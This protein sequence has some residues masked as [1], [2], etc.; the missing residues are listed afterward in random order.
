MFAIELLGLRKQIEQRLDAETFEVPPLDGR[1]SRRRD[2]PD[3]SARAIAPRIAEVHLAVLDDRV[4]P[5][6]DVDRAVGPHLHVHRPEGAMRRDEEV[7]GLSRDV[8]GAVVLEHERVHAIAAEVARHEAPAPR[9]RQMASRDDLET[10]L[11]RLT[12]V[13]SAHHARGIDGRLVRG[14]RERVVDALRAGAVG[15]ERLAE[16]IEMM[17][18]HVDAAAR[19]HVQLHEVRLEPPHAAAEQA[20][21]APRR[22]DVGVDV[23][24]LIEEEVSA[25]APAQ[26]VNDV[27]RV[28]GPEAGEDDAAAV[29]DF[30]AVRVLEVQELG[31]VR[32]VHRQVRH[33]VVRRDAGRNQQVVGEH[34]RDVGAAVA[35]R[36]LEDVD[37][38]CSLFAR[39]DLR[40]QARAHHPETPGRIE[41]HVDRLAQLRARRRTG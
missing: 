19:E 33:A 15:Q 16:R 36:V 41:V 39:L 23:N 20:A 37:L 9:L 14:P 12:G 1:S 2:A 22:L 30:V 11:L 24:R 13:Q 35:V 21:R 10:R 18:P 27:V 38:I 3:A 34:R 25:G 31:R 17:A 29:G 8:S 4:V 5:I 6:R 26:R 28:F 7:F 40:V 32:D